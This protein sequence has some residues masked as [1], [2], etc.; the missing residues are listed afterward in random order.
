MRRELRGL[1]NSVTKICVFS[2]YVFV[3]FI[4]MKS[5]QLE[6][7]EMLW[8]ELRECILNT[9]CNELNFIRS[10]MGHRGKI[11]KE[12]G[13]P[14]NLQWPQKVQYLKQWF[15]DKAKCNKSFLILFPAPI[16][17]IFV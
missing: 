10:V 1:T 14:P 16:E 7:L 9:T 8:K 11:P 3:Y 15:E 17:K 6:N 5:S 13:E 12:H 2:G 4:R